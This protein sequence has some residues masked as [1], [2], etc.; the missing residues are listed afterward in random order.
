MEEIQLAQY[1]LF[2]GIYANAEQQLAIDK[3]E[4][5]M[6]SDRRFFVLDGKGGTGKTTIIKKLVQ[7]YECMG[8]IIMGVAVAHQAKK[9]LGRSIGEEYVKTLASALAIRMNETTGKFY[10]DTYARQYDKVP[11]KSAT[12]IIVDEASMISEELL[13]ELKNEMHWKAKVIF[14][15]DIGQLPPI[16]E[17][18]G[19]SPALYANTDKSDY[20]QLLQRMRQ[21]NLSPI[22]PIS[23]EVYLSTK[24]RSISDRTS[25]FDRENN[26][27]VIYLKK[28]NQ[29]LT[30]AT[31]DFRTYPTDTKLLTYNNE[32]NNH[33][34]SVKNLNFKIRSL[35]WKEDAANQFNIGEIVTAY[36]NYAEEIPGMGRNEILYN[37]EN[38]TVD[39]FRYED[40]VITVE[41]S[42]RELGYRQAIFNYNVCLL[43]L[44]DD[45]GNKIFEE[46][47]VVSFQSQSQYD[48]DMARLWQN[49]Q[50]LAFRLKAQF[51]NIQYGYAVTTHKAQGSGYRNVYV[52]EDNILGSPA[53]VLQKNKA[54]Y[55]AITRAT[56][57]LVMHSELNPE[58]PI[59][60]FKPVK[61]QTNE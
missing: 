40:R 16:G 46:I 37:S 18:S 12:L 6:L 54:L 2:P 21:A 20:A 53:D 50:Q 39:S 19:V 52:F 17:A 28:E 49:D 27:G 34:Q 24:I 7:K 14:M 38:Y 5:F 29:I 44:V 1:E 41:A 51:A 57:K 59:N 47:P 56:T 58:R 9:V 22:V 13:R 61:E 11:I 10:P 25:Y 23:D 48:A 42:S 15:G 45:L 31:R 3:L 4:A 8:A 32:A 55:V 36:D 35:L 33:P 30:E 60:S 26:A 43:T